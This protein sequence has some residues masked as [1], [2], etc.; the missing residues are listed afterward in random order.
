MPPPPPPKSKSDHT[1]SSEPD[2]AQQPTQT[3]LPP[4]AVYPQITTVQPRPHGQKQV[5][6]YTHTIS[7]HTH[8]HARTHARTHANL[9]HFT[10]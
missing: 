6:S 5:C 9:R 8:T 7:N 10:C 1:E 2:R 4:I 3:N